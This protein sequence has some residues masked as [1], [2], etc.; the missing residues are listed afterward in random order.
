MAV[1]DK[2]D[3]W[4]C[5]S[6]GLFLFCN[7]KEPQQVGKQPTLLTLACY[8]KK[9][10][11]GKTDGLV[12]IDLESTKAS[13]EPNWP[14]GTITALLPMPEG[15]YMVC[16]NDFGIL[17]DS[18][19]KRLFSIQGHCSKLTADGEGGIWLAT[20]SGLLNWSESKPASY[21]ETQTMPE[22]VSQWDFNPVDIYFGNL[23]QCL[24]PEDCEGETVLWAGTHQGL[25]RYSSEEYTLTDLIYYPVDSIRDIQALTNGNEKGELLLSGF[26][27]GV[28]TCRESGSMEKMPGVS[29]PVLSMSAGFEG[30]RWAV[31]TDGLYRSKGSMWE[32]LLTE[33]QLPIGLVL[34]AAAQTRP[35]QVWMGTTSGLICYNIDNHMITLPK[36]HPFSRSVT[37]LSYDTLNQLLWAGT[38]AGLFGLQYMGDSWKIMDR[39][40]LRAVSSGLASDRIISLAADVS[41]PE[42]CILWIGTPCGL[43]RFQYQL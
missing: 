18:G 39:F 6:Q 29:V 11:A 14:A 28:Y 31:G 43:S 37:A 17:S 25:F 2:G 5:Y 22:Q 42:N 26:T 32:L 15:L 8:G 7:N 10:W 33:S 30:I 40:C 23:I 3:V 24:T 9:L 20:H 1:T 36:D 34:Q 19:W 16:D 27:G 35:D 41:E 4:A 21:L 13:Q 38:E 12:L